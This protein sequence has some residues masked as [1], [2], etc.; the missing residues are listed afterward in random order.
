M[1]LS[2]IAAA[3]VAITTAVQVNQEKPMLVEEKLSE[4]EAEDQSAAKASRGKLI[5]DVSKAQ[6]A[7]GEYRCFHFP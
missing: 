4:L 7:L 1:K 5:T 3:C 6:Y 2:S